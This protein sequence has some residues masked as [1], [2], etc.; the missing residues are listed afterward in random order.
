MQRVALAQQ[1]AQSSQPLAVQ[2]TSLE[3]AIATKSKEHARLASVL[4]ETSTKMDSIAS[5]GIA[6]EE[7]V[8]VVKARLVSLPTQPETP[9]QVAGPPLDPL[10]AIQTVA[11]LA[12][13]VSH[14]NSMAAGHFRECLAYLAKLIAPVQE[15]S[16][17]SGMS[18]M[19]GASILVEDDDSLGDARP[20]PVASD[21]T[22]SSGVSSMWR[23]ASVAQ[24]ATLARRL[25][26]GPR[27]RTRTVVE[28]GEEKFI[29]V[30]RSR[31]TTRLHCKTTVPETAAVREVP[32]G[33]RYFSQLAQLNGL[34]SDLR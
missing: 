11:S 34:E 10:S 19:D 15:K 17:P 21:A 29:P 13:M 23:G 20:E 6:L 30:T 27:G 14:P 33:T 8:A 9:D 12:G 22:S 2:V 25:S 18:Q 26:L 16:A 32:P 4:Q 7:K 24:Q 28:N 1:H 31:S 3:K 5:E